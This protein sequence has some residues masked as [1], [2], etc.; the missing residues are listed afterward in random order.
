MVKKAAYDLVDRT[1]LKAGDLTTVQP[2]EDHWFVS[3]P[4]GAVLIE[5]YYLEPLGDDIVRRD[6][7]RLLTPGVTD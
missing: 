3:G 6:V 2:G 5:V 7:G 4:E 1:E